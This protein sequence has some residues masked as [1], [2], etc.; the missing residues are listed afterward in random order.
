MKAE[1]WFQLEL[2]KKWSATFSGFTNMDFG[3]LFNVMTKS[4]V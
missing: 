1:Q 2:V 4:N 3:R